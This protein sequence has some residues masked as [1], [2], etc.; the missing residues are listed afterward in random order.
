MAGT[1]FS[2]QGGLA[3]CLAAPADEAARESAA[4][5]A[6][7]LAALRHPFL[8]PVLEARLA[9]NVLYWVN[10]IEAGSPLP[11]PSAQ[12]LLPVLAVVTIIGAAA[13]GLQTAHDA[14]LSH[15]ALSVDSIVEAK[16]GSYA[17]AG[18]GLAGQGAAQDQR[19]LAEIAI[20][21]VAGRRWQESAIS[22]D[23]S[24]AEKVARA[25]RL[26]EQLSGV[27]ERVV[28]VVLRATEPEPTD[29]FNSVTEFAAHFA[30]AVRFS[31]EDLVHAAF[32]SIS[33]RNV[34]LARLLAAKAALYGPTTEGLTLLNLQLQGGSPFGPV[35]VVGGAIPA[36]TM[37]P[38][39]AQS[40]VQPGPTAP[41]GLSGAIPSELTQGLPPEFL[42][43][44]APQ[45]EAVKPKRGIHPMF[46][47][48]IGGVVVVFLLLVAALGTMLLTGS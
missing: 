43:T 4:A 42:E 11:E 15:G 9:G 2:G 18:V 6:A 21:L 13:A 34:E 37:P 1:P 20:V 32:E 10:P 44:I 5:M 25:Q 3:T 16:A 38:E 24:I 47:L 33:A 12:P 14:G 40:L 27:T 48:I 46:V 8:I 29:R 17:V 45:F 39:L 28:N 26:R 41:G 35:S 7:K 23:V 22:A 30:E 36:P 19:D 31:G